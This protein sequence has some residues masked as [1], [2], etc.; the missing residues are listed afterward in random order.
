[1]ATTLV[2]SDEINYLIYRYL[3]ESGFQHTAFTFGMEA[4]IAK[5]NVN[6]AS[7][8]PGALVSFLQKGLQYTELEQAVDARGDEVLYDEPLSLLNTAPAR[9]VVKRERA[10]G[11]GADGKGSMDVDGDIGEAAHARGNSM[12]V[13][14]GGGGARS[15][16][17]GGD[18]GGV[19]VS[20]DEILHLAGHSSEVFICAWSPTASL[21]A[22]GS[23]DATGRIW[24]VPDAPA[25][26]AS[27]SAGVKSVVLR[28]SV[29]HEDARGKDVTTLD[30]APNGTQLAT[31]S[32]DG[33]A[34]IWSNGGELQLT[35]GGHG[36]VAASAAAGGAP[37]SHVGPIF[38]LKWNHSCTLLLSG[39]VDKTAIVWDAATGAVRQQFRLHTAPMLDVDWR[40]DD[41][42]ATCSTDKQVLVCRLGESD[43][44]R[45]F[46]GHTDEVNCVKWGARGRLLA[47]CSDDCTA[48][49]WSVEHA[50]CVHTLS[51]HTKELYTIKW[52]PENCARGVQQLA[53]AS[54]DGTV[55]LWDVER[56]VCAATLDRH[57]E[58]VYSI[59]FS[60]N[61]ELLASGS[62]D[63]SLHIWDLR[64]GCVVKSY[65]GSG[66]IY[67][68]CW[69]RQGT[70]VAACF[71]NNNLVVMDLRT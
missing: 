26:S 41:T 4:N 21:L 17:G 29:P 65:K 71:S 61:G 28:Q 47:S 38:A 14:G 45:T 25:S 11:G 68:V 36:G 13:G 9:S 56:G 70:Q 33:R 62:R 39:S 43:A 20:D 69:N 24:S 50:K 6:T 31:G 63:K 34:R 2:T 22:S 53:S 46:S 67:E 49:L 10:S 37:V 66:G 16:Q 58:A 32:S 7:V 60:P 51:A 55:R 64:D 18:N 52:S 44:Y 1:M 48:R 59:A 35:L 3:Q 15:A 12:G 8:P 42:F 19:L 23:G 54:L 40:D 5:S 27:A 57:S 30:W